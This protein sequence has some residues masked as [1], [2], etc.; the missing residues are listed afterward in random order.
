MKRNF[1]RTLIPA[2]LSVTAHNCAT[3]RSFRSG[4]QTSIALPGSKSAF[5]MLPA[6]VAL[7]EDTSLHAITSQQQFAYTTG[8][9]ASD[10]TLVIDAMDLLHSVRFDGYVG[11]RRTVIL[12]GSRPTSGSKASMWLVLGSRKRQ[13][14]SVRHAAELCIPRTCFRVQRIVGMVRWLQSLCRHP[15]QPCLSSRKSLLCADGK[16]RRSV[17]LGEIGRQLANLASDFD[18]RNFGFRKLGD[19]I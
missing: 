5:A 8:K 12:P 1:Q 10:I 9:N 16:R 4:A 3:I 15:A 11:F 17:A 19:L 2:P 6:P 13:R 7:A 18:P 14:A